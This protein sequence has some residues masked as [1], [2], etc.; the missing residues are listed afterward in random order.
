[1]QPHNDCTVFTAPGT[2][3]PITFSVIDNNE[4]DRPALVALSTNQAL[5]LGKALVAAAE[6]VEATRAMFEVRA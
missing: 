6:R 1:M 3:N 2:A 4:F 5:R